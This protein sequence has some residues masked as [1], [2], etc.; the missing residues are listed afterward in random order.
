MLSL[1]MGGSLYIGFFVC[2]CVS[3][4]PRWQYV[5]FKN[6]KRGWCSININVDLCIVVTNDS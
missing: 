6:S 5:F 1:G 2:V 4:L 3:S